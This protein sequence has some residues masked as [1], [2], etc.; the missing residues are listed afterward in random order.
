MQGVAGVVVEPGDGLGVGAVG[1]WVVS[2]V[3]LPGLVGLLGLEPQVGTLRSLLR[4]RDHQAPAGQGASDSADRDCDLMA[5]AQMPR[6]GVRA[7]VQTGLDQLLADLDD[8]IDGR[9]WRGGGAGVGP[10]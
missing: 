10:A 7:V 6:D 1:Q 4:L 8:Q 5:V 9:L 3:Q 2:E